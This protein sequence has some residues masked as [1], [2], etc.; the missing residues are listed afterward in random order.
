MRAKVEAFEEFQKTLAPKW[1][2]WTP[3]AAFPKLNEQEFWR[4]TD[5][6]RAAVK[7][8]GGGEV[9]QMLR[10]LMQHISAPGAARPA[11]AKSLPAAGKTMGATLAGV[12]RPESAPVKLVAESLPAAGKGG[13]ALL[14]GAGLLTVAATAAL[15]RRIMRSGEGSDTS[16]GLSR[17]KSNRRGSRHMSRAL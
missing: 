5:A 6:M 9:A 10:G 1:A 4:T 14:A 17:K 11:A 12:M 13:G 7:M 3:G 15:A 2:G 16:T 8:E